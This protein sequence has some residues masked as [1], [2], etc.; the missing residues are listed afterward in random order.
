V[1]DYFRELEQEPEDLIGHDE[2]EVSEEQGRLMFNWKRNEA[3]YRLV[4]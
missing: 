1:K 4:D 2:T 3:K